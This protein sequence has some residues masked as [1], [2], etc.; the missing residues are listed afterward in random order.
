MTLT[1]NDDFAA[2]RE[3]LHHMVCIPNRST[4]IVTAGDEEGGHGGMDGASVV[5]RQRGFRPMLARG[6][7]LAHPIVTQKS[8]L[9]LWKDFWLAQK[10]H[11]LTTGYREEKSK[12][13]IRML[14]VRQDTLDNRV[15]VA[16]IGLVNHPREDRGTGG[17]V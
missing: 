15:E 12:A 7:L 5:V 16:H 17:A 1:G 2:L 10:W 3:A 14:G 9:R 13:Q 4:T 6:L 8:P 11:I